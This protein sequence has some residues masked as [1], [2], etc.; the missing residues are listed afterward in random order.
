MNI[1]GMSVSVVFEW[2][3]FALRMPFR[4][5]LSGLFYEFC[6]FEFCLYDGKR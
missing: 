2:D 4:V 6:R 1:S 3:I 5:R